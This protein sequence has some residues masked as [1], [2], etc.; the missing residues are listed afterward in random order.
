MAIAG[1]LHPVE[2]RTGQPAND[3]TP[4]LDCPPCDRT[5]R[6][7][8]LF[9]SCVRLAAIKRTQNVLCSRSLPNKV[10]VHI[11]TKQLSK[12]GIAKNPW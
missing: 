5:E 11:L 2:L 1:S 3:E 4:A 12:T 8:L 10:F 7:W 9:F 6:N